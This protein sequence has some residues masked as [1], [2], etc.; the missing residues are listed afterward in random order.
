MKLIMADLRRL[1]R[2]KKISMDYNGV[3]EDLQYKDLEKALIELCNLKDSIIDKTYNHE[4]EYFYIR[5]NKRGETPK[6][7]DLFIQQSKKYLIDETI[8]AI[9]ANNK[10]P[11]E[12]IDIYYYGR[13]PHHLVVYN[14]K[15][16]KNNA[17]IQNYIK[18]ILFGID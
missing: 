5:L 3:K 9:L 4:A 12:N 1:M 18:T 6:Y 7:K 10:I 11:N 16:A 8:P 17:I 13:L 15:K 2:N 14:G